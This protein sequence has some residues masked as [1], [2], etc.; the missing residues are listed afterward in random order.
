MIRYGSV[1]FRGK[2]FRCDGDHCAIKVIFHCQFHQKFEPHFNSSSFVKPNQ[3]GRE[4]W[5]KITEC[6]EKLEICYFNILIGFVINRFLE[7]V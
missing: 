2:F 6:G 5:E 3:T 4:Q 7:T 1:S